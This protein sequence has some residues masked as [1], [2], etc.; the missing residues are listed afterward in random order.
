MSADFCKVSLVEKLQ[1]SKIIILVG[2][3]KIKLKSTGKKW[4]RKEWIFLN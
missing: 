3:K 2:F 1:K 4:D